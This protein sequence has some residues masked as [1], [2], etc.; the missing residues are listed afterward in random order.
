MA[1]ERGEWKIWLTDRNSLH[2]YWWTQNSVSKHQY[3]CEL[4]LGDITASGHNPL[5][6]Q[7]NGKQDIHHHWFQEY[8]TDSC[9]TVVM[10]CFPCS[11]HSLLLTRSLGSVSYFEFKYYLFLLWL[12]I[13]LQVIAKIYNISATCYNWLVCWHIKPLHS[14]VVALK[15]G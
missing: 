15:N 13:T 1:E 7:L 8:H 6:L 2:L 14:H 3:N 11:V 5:A 4:T 12:F 10:L 9:F